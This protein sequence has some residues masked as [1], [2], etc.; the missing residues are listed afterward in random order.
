MIK[1]RRFR[2]S[3]RPYAVDLGS[4][5]TPGMGR[6]EIDAVWFRRRRQRY[7]EPVRTIACAGVLHEYQTPCRTA[8]EDFLAAYTDPRRGGDCLA[9]WDGTSLWSNTDETARKAYLD[10][11]V[12]MLENSPDVPPG[13]SGW[14]VFER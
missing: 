9:R 7:G 3:E 4:Y 8:V 10:I 1:A 6:G 11:L 2:M 13:Y 14:W 12:P 5:R